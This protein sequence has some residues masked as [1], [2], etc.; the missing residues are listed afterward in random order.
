M[1]TKSAAGM[2]LL[3]LC[4]SLCAQDTASDT[5]LVIRSE[6]R[7]VAIDL[8]VHDKKG[9]AI[10]GLTAK[11]FTVWEDGK[12]QMITS[13]S[14]GSA[15]PEASAKH[16][17]LLF[18]NSVS[19]IRDQEASRRAAARFVE[20]LAAPD[21]YMAVASAM[22]DAVTIHQNF[23]TSG[24]A[25]REGIERA[26]PA[27]AADGTKATPPDNAPPPPGRVINPGVS[28]TVDQNNLPIAQGARGGVGYGQPT[29]PRMDTTPR[30][31][32]PARALAAWLEAVAHSL[33]AAPGRKAVI[34]FSGKYNLVSDSDRSIAQVIQACNR[35]NVAVYAVENG[36]SFATAVARGTGGAVYRVDDELSEN[37]AAIAREQDTYYRVG[38]MPPSSADGACHSIRIKVND[39]N[40]EIRSRT[41]YCTS[42]PVAIVTAKGS[43]DGAKSVLADTAGTSSTASISLPFFYTGSNRARVYVSVDVIPGGVK[44]AKAGDTLNARIAVAGVA[45]SAEGGTAAQ[46][47]DAVDLS[48]KTRAEADAFVQAPWHYEHQFLVGSGRY[49]FRMAFAEG[50]AAVA[51]VEAPLDVPSWDSATL[52]MGALALCSGGQKAE[53]GALEL[54]ENAALQ[55]SGYSFSPL[56]SYRFPRTQRVY[57]YTEIYDPGLASS[58]LPSI[59]MRYRIV[60][61]RTGEM[62]QDS[63]KADIRNF[64]K[65]GNSHVA[66]ATMLPIEKLESGAY[67]LEVTT[68]HSSG[69]ESVKRSVEFQIR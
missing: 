65:P 33:A 2:A 28:G 63:G 30:T 64:V 61:A 56:A 38:Y 52:G 24:A 1:G 41:E 48:R 18:D 39:G 57:L 8:A 43:G 50:D 21:R 14:S 68:E 67:R 62:K 27:A 7:E 34:L 23:T 49:Q 3:I 20:S 10:A 42:R 51:R 32:D 9:G 45:S 40:P 37:L 6:V 15:D 12:K 13:V 4:A 29:G 19:P 47:T 16:I 69:S 35:A 54:E 44:F 53:T 26:T 66:V 5:P 58:P 25:L 55:A 60:D 17:V 11:D 59:S 22:F 36:S 31:A 46:F